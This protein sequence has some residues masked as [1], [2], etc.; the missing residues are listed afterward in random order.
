MGVSKSGESRDVNEQLEDSIVG[1]R[2]FV[3]AAPF[4]LGEEVAWSSFRSG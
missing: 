1:D 4:Q 3:N 2:D